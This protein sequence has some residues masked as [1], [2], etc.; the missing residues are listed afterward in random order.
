[1][2]IDKS[3]SIKFAVGDY[4]SSSVLKF[5]KAGFFN[6]ITVFRNRA[7]VPE[8]GLHNTRIESF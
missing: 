2:S 6:D 7:A 5:L 3:I 4:S 1:M 8:V